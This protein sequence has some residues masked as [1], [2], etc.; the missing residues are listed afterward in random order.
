M[1]GDRTIEGAVHGTAVNTHPVVH[2]ARVVE[3]DRVVPELVRLADVRELDVAQVCLVDVQHL[4]VGPEGVRAGDVLR[5]DDA[6]V[7]R[8]QTSPRGNRFEREADG[9]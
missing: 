3:V 6:D 7:A 8:E 4:D 2:H 9:T 5:P 1:V